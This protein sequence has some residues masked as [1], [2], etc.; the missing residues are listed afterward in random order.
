MRRVAIIGAGVVG[1]ALG[2]LLNRGGFP[3]VGIASRTLR[4]AEKAKEFIGSGQASTDLSSTARKADIVFI[5]TSDRAIK[6]A[7]DRISS[8]KGFNPGV[9]V[10]H[11]CGALPSTIL[12]SARKNS[13]EIASLHPLQSFANTKAAV[14]S[15]PG[16]YFCLEGDA[17]ALSVGRDIIKV[18]RGKEMRLSI[19]KKPLYHAGA[20]AASNF[21]VATVGL[22]IEF[23][24]A[25]GIPGEDSLRALAPLIKGTVKNIENAGIPAA[26]TGP[27]ARGDSDVI[28]D[29]LRVISKERPELLKI[30]TELGRYTAKVAVR[31]GTLKDKTAKSIISLFDK[32]EE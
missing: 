10:F 31:K 9:I 3:V 5:T 11:T 2:Y 19:K 16:S 7:C 23:F 21:L 14:R 22:G 32:Y 13:A 24:E 20:C 30:Y 15:L 29:H 6:G 4:S 27:I 18:L 1:T 12:Q 17:G 25:A 28:E 26:L 8:E